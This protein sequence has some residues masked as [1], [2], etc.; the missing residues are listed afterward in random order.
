MR[1][2]ILL[3]TQLVAA[4]AQRQDV[5]HDNRGWRKEENSSGFDHEFRGAPRQQFSRHSVRSTSGAPPQFSRPRFDGSTYSR[6]PQ[7]LRVSSSRI[8]SGSSQTRSSV[9]RCTQCRRLHWGPCRRGLDVCYACAR[10]GH[11]KRNC[12]SL[13]GKSEVRTTGMVMDSSSSACPPRPGP[14]MLVGG[15]RDQRGTPSPSG[16]QHHIHALAERQDP[17]SSPD[18]VPGILLVS[19]YDMCAS[20][21]SDPMLSCITPVVMI[22]LR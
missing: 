8:R 2:A 16:S 10:P 6:S 22:V 7:S 21:D 20:I 13:R 19:S 12:P 11:L 18:I 4:Q 17:E 14:Q 9:P 15:D 1:Q 3:L 5:G